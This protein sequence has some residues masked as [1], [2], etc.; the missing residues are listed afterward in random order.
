MVDLFCVKCGILLSGRKTKFCSKKCNST[1][2]SRMDRVKNGNESRKKWQETHREKYLELMRRGN[3]KYRQNHP[4][5]VREYMRR[6]NAKNP[7]KQ[8][9][10][11]LVSREK[12]LIIL[13]N[14]NI[15]EVCGSNKKVEKHHLDY[16]RPYL[17]IMLCQECHKFFDYNLKK[18]IMI[19][20]LNNP[21]IEEITLNEKKCKSCGRKLR[22]LEE[23]CWCCQNQKVLKNK[24]TEL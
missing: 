7:D 11:H 15:C 12:I 4:D 21:I 8:R 16:K 3:K 10:R 13:K 22:K 5:K 20:P 19:I 9:A 23:Y 6:H 1:Y 18:G 14:R 17:I 24:K 2:F